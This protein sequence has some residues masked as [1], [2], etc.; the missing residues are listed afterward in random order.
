M[1]ISKAQKN[2]IFK[3]FN[4]IVSRNRFSH[5]IQL[6]NPLN[7]CCIRAR[8]SRTVI[9][10]ARTYSPSFP[11]VIGRC[12]T[13]LIVINYVD[14]LSYSTYKDKFELVNPYDKNKQPKQYNKAEMQVRKNSRWTNAFIVPDEVAENIYVGLNKALDLVKEWED[15]SFILLADEPTEALA[16]VVRGRGYK[17]CIVENEPLGSLDSPDEGC[18]IMKQTQFK[19]KHI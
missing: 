8:E 11:D 7:Y 17:C 10:N 6:S 9:T 3:L 2:N 18:L 1:Y 15:E 5:Y 16:E 19:G 4:C 13:N 12:T 14:D